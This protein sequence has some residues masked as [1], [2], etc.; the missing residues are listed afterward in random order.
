[1]RRRTVSLCVDR[2]DLVLLD[3]RWELSIHG[4]DLVK[5][6][7]GHLSRES[8]EEKRSVSRGRVWRD[9]MFLDAR[10]ACLNVLEQG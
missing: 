8:P 6:G 2:D 4:L 1:M 10:R 7:L 5:H 3:G 9:T